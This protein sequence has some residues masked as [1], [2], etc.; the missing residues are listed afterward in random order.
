MEV[1]PMWSLFPRN[2][3]AKS[4]IIMAE[5]KINHDHQTYFSTGKNKKDCLN[6]GKGGTHMKQNQNFSYTCIRTLSLQ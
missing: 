5:V 4:V 6:K 1:V 3:Q 2:K